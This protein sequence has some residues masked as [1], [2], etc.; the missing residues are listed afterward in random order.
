MGLPRIPSRKR[1]VESEIWRELP[2]F[3][4]SQGE[5]SPSQLTVC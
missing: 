4:A 5:I 2:S 3:L 1:N